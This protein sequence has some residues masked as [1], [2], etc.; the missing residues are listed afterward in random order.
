MVILV[1]FFLYCAFCNAMAWPGMHDAL[2]AQ[3]LILPWRLRIALQWL[4][5]DAHLAHLAS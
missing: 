4:V 2:K 1:E 5:S 3:K